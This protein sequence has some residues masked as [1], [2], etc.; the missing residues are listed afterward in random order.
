MLCI[1]SVEISFSQKIWKKYV[2]YIEV[3]TGV[4]VGMTSWGLIFCAVLYEGLASESLGSWAGNVV[5][6]NNMFLKL[7][8]ISAKAWALY[9]NTL[10]KW[11]VFI[12]PDST[13]E[14][15]KNENLLC[16]WHPFSNISHLMCALKSSNSCLS[17]WCWHSFFPYSAT[18]H[19]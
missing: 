3:V 8:S 10:M 12:S 19:L 13:N 9:Q 17:Y 18:G 4:A 14:A 1:F 2:N 6:W 11:L 7:H 5:F 16:C 15:S